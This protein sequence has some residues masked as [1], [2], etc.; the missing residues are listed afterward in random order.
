[1]PGLGFD[2]PNL[3]PGFTHQSAVTG[4]PDQY[5]N[6]DAFELQP[7][8]TLGNLG[9]GTFIG[10]NL[11]TVD[12]QTMKRFF[13]DLR[14]R[15]SELQFRFEIFNLLNRANFAT[16]SLLAFSGVRDDEAPLPTLGQIRSTSTS[17]RQIQL[18][19]RLLF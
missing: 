9:R 5:F 12:L 13:F 8:G 3:A 15:E 4:N 16:P 10:P 19:V 17:A 2:R 1:L 18:G 7:A 14:G 11:R 6:P